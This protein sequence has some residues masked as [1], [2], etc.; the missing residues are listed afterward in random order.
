[1]MGTT[2]ANAEIYVNPFAGMMVTDITAIIGTQ[3]ILDM[4]GDALIGGLRV[5]IQSEGSFTAGIVI[6][7]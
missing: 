6:A 2:T 1:M 5:G 3:R 4:G 7:W